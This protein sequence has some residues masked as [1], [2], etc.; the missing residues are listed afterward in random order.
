MTRP[1]FNGRPATSEDL[2]RV[3]DHF[4]ERLHEHEDEVEARLRALEDWRVEMFTYAR[5]VK[6]TLGASIVGAVVSV[7]NL[8][9]LV[10]AI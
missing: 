10:G 6:Y 2:Q 7:I 3:M 9:G 5:I 8:I 4:D 1:T